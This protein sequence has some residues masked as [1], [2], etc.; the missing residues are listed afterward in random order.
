MTGSIIHPDSR[1]RTKQECIHGK[2]VQLRRLARSDSAAFVAAA[3]ASRALHGAWV[4]PPATAEAFAARWKRLHDDPRTI[5]LVAIRQ[6]DAALVGVFNLSEIIRGPLQQAY[7][8]Y[9]AFAPHAGQGYMRE[10]MDLLLRYAF[11]TLKL[12]RIEANIQPKNASSIA[13][14][15]AAGFVKEGF[16]ERYLKI[17]GRWRD[18]ERW[19]IHAE[20]WK[21]QRAVRRGES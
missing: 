8:G 13:L 5:S 17:A 3:Q 21:R 2:R 1:Q 18:H 4:S 12:H 19:A 11:S 15:Q 7:L 20:R 6:S 9:Y 10:A 16:S 14:A